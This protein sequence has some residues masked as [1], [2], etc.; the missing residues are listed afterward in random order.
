LGVEFEDSSPEFWG[1]TYN[2]HA[3]EVPWNK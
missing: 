3:I 1:V 2:P